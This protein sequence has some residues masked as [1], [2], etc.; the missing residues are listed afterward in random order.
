MDEGAGLVPFL[1]SRSPQA[2]QASLEA[3]AAAMSGE[4][5][6]R[7]ALEPPLMS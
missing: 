3:Q 1:M 7:A 2:L 6:E 4:A 5:Y